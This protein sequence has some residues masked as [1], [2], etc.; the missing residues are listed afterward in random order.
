MRDC[1]AATN[2]DDLHDVTK[3][4]DEQIDVF[5]KYLNFCTDLHLPSTTHKLYQNKKP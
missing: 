3:P 4:I 2:W 5:S 1:L